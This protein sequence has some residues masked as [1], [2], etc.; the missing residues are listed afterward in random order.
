MEPAAGDEGSRADT[1]AGAITIV[2]A[3]RRFQYVVLLRC[4]LALFL[5]SIDVGAR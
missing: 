4:Y 1:V 5:S 2:V 3:R